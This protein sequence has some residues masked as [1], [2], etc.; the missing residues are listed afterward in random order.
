MNIGESEYVNAELLE[1]FQAV[2]RWYRLKKINFEA[3]V[4]DE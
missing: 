2:P 3:D 4:P 1:K